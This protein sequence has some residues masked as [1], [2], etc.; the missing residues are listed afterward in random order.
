M[1]E[2]CY[3]K[4]AGGK[5]ENA[6]K[7]VLSANATD[8]R[9]ALHRDKTFKSLVKGKPGE[10]AAP[11]VAS[12]LSAAHQQQAARPALGCSAHT[13]ELH[14]SNARGAPWQSH[15]DSDLHERLRCHRQRMPRLACSFCQHPGHCAPEDRPERPVQL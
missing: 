6:G 7:Q 5:M 4:W 10:K 1:C 11:R 9:F 2:T 13:Q 15:S 12:G 3:D 8:H 14:K